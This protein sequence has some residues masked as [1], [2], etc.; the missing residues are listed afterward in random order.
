[1][2]SYHKDGDP[3]KVVQILKGKAHDEVQT[4]LQHLLVHLRNDPQL[5]QPAAA[6]QLLATAVD[7]TAR[8][9]TYL[10]YPY[11]FAL[12]CRKWFPA[13]RQ[14]Q[15][16]IT[17]FLRE[18]PKELDKGFSLPFQEMALSR[19]DEQE[20]RVVLM[21]YAVQEFLEEAAEA[22][23]MNS[24]HAERAGATVKRYEIRQLSLLSNVSRELLHKQF[25]K[26]REAQALE[27]ERWAARVRK[28]RKTRWQSI[29]W[30]LDHSRPIGRHISQDNRSIVL[31]PAIA[32]G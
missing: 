6:T 7:L 31:E 12:M 23:L 5:D 19:N 2:S 14:Y 4:R 15:N 1:M 27:M 25:V 3:P 13:P 20:Q 30:E 29:A 28:L 11:K 9:D 17:A 16:A 32:H 24:L 18:S 10:A 8:L 21:S 26:C 22:L